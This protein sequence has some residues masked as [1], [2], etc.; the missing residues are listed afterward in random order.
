MKIAIIVIAVLTFLGIFNVFFAV[1][2]VT[3]AAVTGRVSRLTMPR[4]QRKKGLFYRELEERKQWLR[5]QPLE[6]CQVTAKDGVTLAGH[7]LLCE[8]PRAV[9]VMMPGYRISAEDQ[10]ARVV[11]MYHNRNMITLLAEERGFAPSGGMAITFGIKES[12]D[13]AMWANYCAERFGEQMPIFLL[14]MSMGGGAVLMSVNED[15]PSSVK[16]VIADC[17]FSSPREAIEKGLNYPGNFFVEKVDYWLGKI[18]K[19]NLDDKT[20]VKELEKNTTLP[21]MFIHGTGDSV[22][23]FH[24]AKENLSACAAPHEVLFVDGAEHG[25]CC[26]CAENFD[27]R[28]YDFMNRCM[29]N[30]Y[31]ENYCQF[32]NTHEAC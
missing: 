24:M 23:P 10:F 25:A 18:W 14:G 2:L 16:G 19:W 11:Q 12:E 26:L 15:L 20:S 17:A 13:C 4:L 3:A 31:N 9:V 7:L 21:V 6:A 8:K 27:E 28:V 22:V 30:A 5:Q 1:P 32:E 29:S